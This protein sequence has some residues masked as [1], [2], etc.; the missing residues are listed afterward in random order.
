MLSHNLISHNQLEGWRESFQKIDKSTNKTTDELN[1]INDYYDCL[2]ECDD[3]QSACKRICK[4]V[5]T[6]PPI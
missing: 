3:N 1:L 2:I 5:L 4:H 6:S